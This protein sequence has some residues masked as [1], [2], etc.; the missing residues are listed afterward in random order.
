MSALNSLLITDAG[1]GVVRKATIEEVISA[2]RACISYKLRRGTA[3]D[4]PRA[5]R[6][7]LAVRFGERQHEVFCVIYLDLCGADTYV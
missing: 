2:A 1:T 3:L 6:D 4:S 7:Y 5:A